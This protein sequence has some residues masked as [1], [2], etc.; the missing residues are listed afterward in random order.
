MTHKTDEEIVDTLVDLMARH[1]KQVEYKDGHSPQTLLE[2]LTQTLKTVREQA[3]KRGAE[4]ERERIIKVMEEE[5]SKY[6]LAHHTRKIDHSSG[7]GVGF[8]DAVRCLKDKALTPQ[9]LTNNQ[10]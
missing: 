9:N 7:M 8:R 5:S 10:P 1:F 4:V 2:D 3:E 6:H